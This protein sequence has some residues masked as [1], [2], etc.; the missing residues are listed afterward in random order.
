MVKLT[1]A[2]IERKCSETQSNKSLTKEIDK[3]HVKKLTHLFM[4][5]KFITAI[6]N[7]D[8]CTNLKIIYLHN[9]GI[10][11]IEN[12]NFANQLSELYLQHNNLTKIEN[13]DSLRNLKKLYLGYNK[14]AI[15]EGLENLTSLRELYIEKQKLDP[16][17][18]LC[19]EP[20]SCATLATCLMILNVSG[21][22]IYNL[23]D[24][25]NLR[26]LKVLE[27]KYNL[28]ENIQDLL[29]AINNLPFLQE[30]HLQGNP[31]TKKFRYRENVIAN[32][33]KLELLDEKKISENCSKFFKRFKIE[34]ELQEAKKKLKAGNN[35]IKEDCSI[36]SPK[37]SISTTMLHVGSELLTNTSAT[38]FQPWKASSSVNG[39]LKENHKLSRPFWKSVS[40]SKRNEI[41]V[42]PQEK[43]STLPFI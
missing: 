9:N 33:D 11:K 28:L 22:R 23:N 1:T 26:K 7:I 29:H 8:S 19:F 5:N 18:S 25:R 41:P 37:L 40:K 43:F 6:G 30:L 14:I 38:K 34:R 20:R 16:G 12:L 21:N 31:V 42:F 2:L 39:F 36:P 4:N 32:H 3:E 27:A 10:N 15:V 24:V 17:E 13:L 35:E